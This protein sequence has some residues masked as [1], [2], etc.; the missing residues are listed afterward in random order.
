LIRKLAKDAI[1][2]T[3]DLPKMQ[4]SKARAKEPAS[5]K[6]K[7]KN[8]KKLNSKNVEN[9]VRDLAGIRLIFYTNTD[10]DAFIQ[11]R[12]I[13]ENFEVHWEYTRIH[14]PVEENEYERYQGIHYT[15]SLSPKLAKLQKYKKFKGMRCEIQIHSV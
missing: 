11:S 5:L 7:L 9:E 1:L 8:N 4:S 10:V 6:R 2:K 12:I 15:V 13:P 3:P 14:H